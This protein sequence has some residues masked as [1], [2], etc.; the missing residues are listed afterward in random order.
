[1]DANPEQDTFELVTDFAERFFQWKMKLE[2]ID[3]VEWNEKTIGTMFA[4]GCEDLVREIEANI[5]YGYSEKVQQAEDKANNI[6][7][8]S[9]KNSKIRDAEAR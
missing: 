5:N 2:C 6:Q 3:D 9:P 4:K 8:L 7:L 1:M